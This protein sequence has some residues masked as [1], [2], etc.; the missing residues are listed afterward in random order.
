RPGQGSSGRGGGRSVAMLSWMFENTLVVLALAAVAALASRALRARPALCHLVW[1]VLLARLVAPPVAIGV[2]PE[3]E[4]A[5]ATLSD[6]A[7]AL[8]ALP[9]DE[10]LDVLRAEPATPLDAAESA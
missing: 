10:P 5:R 1:L 4:L 3:L 8:P 2:L 6:R 7:R 9:P